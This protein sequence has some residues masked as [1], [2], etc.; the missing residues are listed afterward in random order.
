M[1]GYNAFNYYKYELK[2][3]R[4]KNNFEFFDEIREKLLT[5]SQLVI[6]YHWLKYK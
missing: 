2:Q 4:L 3:F 5:D 1:K 6:R